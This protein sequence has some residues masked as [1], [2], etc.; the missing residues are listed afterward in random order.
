MPIKADWG[1][2]KI[3]KI[4]N[5][6]AYIHFRDDGDRLAK[7]YAIGDNPLQWAESQSDPDLDHLGTLTHRKP[8]S[9]ASKHHLDFDQALE[10]FKGKYDQMF[11][12]P[13]YVGDAKGGERVPLE[14]PSKLFQDSFGDGQLGKM[15]ENHNYQVI[16][17]RALALLSSQNLL[18]REELRAFREVLRNEPVSLVYFD[19]LNKIL[20]DWHILY[21]SMNPYFETV[22]FNPIPGFAKW[23][24][25]TLLPF[26]AQ[27]HR[28]MFLKP[29]LTKT[30]ASTLG[31][32]FPYEP[33]LG[34]RTYHSLEM[35]ATGL[36]EK[37]K[38]S[39]ARDFLDVQAFITL[40]LEASKTK[41]AV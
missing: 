31:I 22:R 21:D 13:A 39:G 36:L 16:A 37:L 17:D 26:L 28:H 32:A 14:I 38:L 9:F 30:F 23:P 10:L 29:H 25:A 18:A 2:G 7:K 33:K 34:W 15:L 35:M 27:P 20:K 5:G 6:Y 41:T 8:R 3:M 1:P 11:S 12:D 19:A 4:E 40:V 24:N